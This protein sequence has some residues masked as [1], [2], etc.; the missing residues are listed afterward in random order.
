MQSANTA[1]FAN[2]V[3]FASPFACKPTE[4]LTNGDAASGVLVAQGRAQLGL[5]LDSTRCARTPLFQLERQLELVFL[6][7]R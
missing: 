3:F 5:K 6:T 2:P 7:S 1:S 4:K